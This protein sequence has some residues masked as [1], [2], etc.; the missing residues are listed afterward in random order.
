M[1]DGSSSAPPGDEDGWFNGPQ[2]VHF[3]V[4]ALLLFVV[5][6]GIAVKLVTHRVKVRVEEGGS[7]MAGGKSISKS[8]IVVHMAAN[9]GHMLVYKICV[10]SFASCL[11]FRHASCG[12]WRYVPIFTI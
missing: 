6:G 12:S 4:K 9:L 5:I 1:T 3:V 11:C 7:K 8:S 2:V 10:T